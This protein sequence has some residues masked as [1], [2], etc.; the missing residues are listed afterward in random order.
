MLPLETPPTSPFATRIP[1]LESHLR[2]GASY[3]S[4][5]RAP[6]P[7]EEVGSGVVSD[8]PAEPVVLMV[9]VQA[10]MLRLLDRE[11]VEKWA[12]VLEAVHS[13]YPGYRAFHFRA[14]GGAANADDWAS[15]PPSEACCF[16]LPACRDDAPIPMYTDTPAERTQLF[17]SVHAAAASRP[18][19][20]HQ[21]LHWGLLSRQTDEAS[22]IWS[23][24]HTVLLPAHLL[25]LDSADA[26][27]PCRVLPLQGAVVYHR[28]GD[29]A[30]F[31]LRAE[32]WTV[33]FAA[34]DASTRARW[35][36][37]L[38][39]CVPVGTL[40]EDGTPAAAPRRRQ[41]YWGHAL[42]ALASA[43]V[44]VRSFQRELVV[45]EEVL[46]KAQQG[47]DELVAAAADKLRQASLRGS[48][49][50]ARRTDRAGY[51]FVSV[52]APA[53]PTGAPSARSTAA[54]PSVPRSQLFQLLDMNRALAADIADGEYDI[55]MLQQAVIT[56]GRPEWA[57]GEWV[58]YLHVTDER[59]LWEVWTRAHAL[60]REQQLRQRLHELDERQKEEERLEEAKLRQRQR[61]ATGA[62]L[63]A[64]DEAIR[65]RDRL[66]QHQQQS[67]RQRWE[68]LAHDAHSDFRSHPA[69]QRAATEED[70]A[71]HTT[72][73][74]T[75]L[76]DFSGLL[77]LKSG[78]SA[79]PASPAALPQSLAPAGAVPPT[80]APPITLDAAPV[81]PSLWS[82]LSGDRSLLGIDSSNR[83]SA[84]TRRSAAKEHDEDWF[85]T[86]ANK[87]FEL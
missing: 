31:T 34:R 36:E 32:R 22:E 8:D 33:H 80:P 37:A 60:H 35:L 15:A 78:I 58:W 10:G 47:A 3:H 42:S 2:L 16:C 66:Q 48:T 27:H 46:T 83:S 6:L 40:R 70:S 14:G 4:A 1:R 5:W 20:P 38:T 62:D 84:T 69:M 51:P 57:R 11:G 49:L 68:Q 45:A 71:P 26:E 19:T 43:L 56:L 29:S 76:V 86:F 59:T 50:S 87:V 7:S 21:P 75:Q 61:E 24:T 18:I 72:A 12:M 74:P 41:Y 39:E 73:S 55:K 54:P 63:L 65:E 85:M 17:A 52:G 28:P 79:A 53:T 44:R 82:A 23:N 9:D 77:P 67:W 13:L 64:V 25:L 30:V 81:P